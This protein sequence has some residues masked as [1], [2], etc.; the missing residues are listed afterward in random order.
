M[1]SAFQLAKKYL[2]YYFTAAN[3]KGHGVH[4]PFVFEFIRGVLNDHHKYS[5]FKDVER[6]RRR[7]LGDRRM[8][9][10]DDFGAGST[11]I[12]SKR[13]A[14][15]KIAASSLKSPRY[16]KLLAGIASHYKCKNIIELGT[17][18]G[19]STSSMALA[20][21]AAKLY[22]IEGSRE[23]ANIAKET[24]DHLGIK[25][26]ELIIG[27]FDETFPALLQRMPKPDLI[28]VDGN[29]REE[30]TLRY[31][32]MALKEASPG[33]ILIFDDIHWSAEME[34]AWSQI[35]NDPR[36]TLTVDLFF[37]GLAFINPDFKVKQQF[38]IR[39]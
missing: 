26:I 13:R 28:F 34:R 23:I 11:V 15:S 35:S 32:N 8:I 17:S 4:S 3:G 9:N 12:K 33:L 20:S 22:S 36:V 7:L 19:I 6:Q 38:K 14:V 2:H 21:P 30:P 1:Y 37:L 16:S 24:F 5:F 31:F 10:V 29:H 27:N 25:N 18:F 39:Y